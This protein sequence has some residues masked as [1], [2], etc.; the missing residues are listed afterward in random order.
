MVFITNIWTGFP[1][2]TPVLYAFQWEEKKKKR[3]M[4]LFIK[5]QEKIKE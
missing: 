1:I 3:G 5:S 4:F 2:E